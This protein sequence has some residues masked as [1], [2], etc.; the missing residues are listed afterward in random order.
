M[1]DALLEFGA[2]VMRTFVSVEGEVLF[3]S[4]AMLLPP[5]RVLHDTNLRR[6]SFLFGREE[7]KNVSSGGEAPLENK[8]KLGHRARLLFRQAGGKEGS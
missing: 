8:W 1:R 2:L 3:L 7:G 4:S 5:F 6:V